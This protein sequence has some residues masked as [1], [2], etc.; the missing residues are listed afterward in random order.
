[1]IWLAGYRPLVSELVIF[2]RASSVRPKDSVDLAGVDT[3]SP[4]GRLNR[5]DFVVAELEIVAVR[6]CRH[7]DETVLIQKV[8][9]RS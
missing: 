2:D 9:A 3:L 8:F 1:L 6:R 4:K 5:P 7:L